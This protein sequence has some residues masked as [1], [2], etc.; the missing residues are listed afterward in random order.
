[1]DINLV[2]QTDRLTLRVLNAGDAKRLHQLWQ[3]SAADM[4][5]WLEWCHDEM[6]LLDAQSWIERNRTQWLTNQSYEMGV[7]AFDDFSQQLQL[8]GAVYLS[9]FDSVAN[10][11]CLGYWVATPYTGCGYAVEAAEWMAYLAF[12]DLLFTRLELVIDPKNAASIRVAEKI[13]AQYECH[14]RNRYTYH[15]VPKDGLVYSLISSDL[16]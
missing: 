5:P 2:F 11:A 4:S 7:F 9:S 3:Q 16:D 1:M 15:G 12:S 14:A 13:G 8:V 6:T 10:Q